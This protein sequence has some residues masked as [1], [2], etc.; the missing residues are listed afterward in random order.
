MDTFVEE[1]TDVGPID[2]SVKNR[3]RWAWLDEKGDDETP[4]RSWCKKMKK[5]GV[6][7]CVI[8]HKTIPYG[9]NGKKVL[10]RHQSDASHKAA[11]RSL[12]HTSRL[13]GAS[14]T[15]TNAHAS[16]TDRVCNLKVRVCAFI[17]EHDL[18]L[19]MSQP[20]V[21]LVKSCAADRS[22]LSR[23]SISNSHASY[24]CTYGLA[25]RYRA[26]LSSKLQGVHFSLNI[27]EATN[28]NADRILNALIR[29][30]DEEQG[31][32]LTLHLGS[33]KANV[34]D[35]A[36]ITNIVSDILATYF[37][38]WDQ[39]ISV[40]LDNCNVMRGKKSGVET[41][42]RRENPALLD[43][44]GDTVHMVSNGAKAL[45]APFAG[46]VEDF[47]RHVYCDIEKFPKQKE[48]FS[49]LQSLLHLEPKSLIRPIHTR[50]LQMLDVCNRVHELL[51]PLIVHYHS[52]LA[53]AEK[54]KYR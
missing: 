30:Y 39:T 28:A 15:T 42:I 16:M 40:L 18:S 49:E 4:I 29:Y 13:P 22:A 44:S 36:T 11:V 35:S 24:L 33:R 43:I 37:V 51:D 27:D 46:F 9:S 1:G 50:F 20:L 45:F 8:C 6:C 5:P 17:A 21:D 23:L 41:L 32:V 38:K 19:T 52:I 3:W 26:E 47:C 14:E 7:M 48:H 25:A 53:P 10:I 2:K 34:A 54:H 12:Q 31:K